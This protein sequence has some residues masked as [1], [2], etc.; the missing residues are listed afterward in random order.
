MLVPAR[1][2][3]I[4]TFVPFGPRSLPATSS[5]VSPLVEALS[6]G[7][8]LVVP[9]QADFLRRRVADDMRNHEMARVGDRVAG[10][11]LIVSRLDLHAHA[12]ELAG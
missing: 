6:I 11:A 2:T 8:D 7:H 3:V 12:R 5:T 9:R 4:S 10:V 1:S